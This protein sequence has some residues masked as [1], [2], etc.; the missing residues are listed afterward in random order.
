MSVWNIKNVKSDEIF[1]CE[2]LF[3]MMALVKQGK[4]A[5]SVSSA[6]WSGLQ[7][8]KVIEYYPKNITIWADD[9]QAGL[10][11]AKVLQRF[12]AMYGIRCKTVKSKVAKDAAEHFLEKQLTW[13]DVEDINITR[14]MISSKED[15]SFN[16]LKYLN[17]RKF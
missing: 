2:G 11:C 9:D 3:D 14:E 13:D 15:M 16:F 7:L 8:L 10:R 5:I 4:D 17:E 12:F 6:M 1:I